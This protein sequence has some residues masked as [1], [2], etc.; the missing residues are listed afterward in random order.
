MLF[1]WIGTPV[2]PRWHVALTIW[3][4]TICLFL[5][6]WIQ[7][8]GGAKS[9][10]LLLNT[11][12]VW[13]CMGP[14]QQYLGQRCD[15]PW[16]RVEPSKHNTSS[17]KSTQGVGL[18]WKSC[19][20]T[21]QAMWLFSYKLVYVEIHIKLYMQRAGGKAHLVHTGLLAVIATGRENNARGQIGNF[22]MQ[23][24]CGNREKRK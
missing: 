18:F 21:E 9:V 17:E 15:I 16:V 24:S 2:R 6:Q 7:F 11:E 1:P 3:S 14:G 23:G 12:L 10:H 8:L 13:Q 22:P 20:H 5:L 4:I 19:C